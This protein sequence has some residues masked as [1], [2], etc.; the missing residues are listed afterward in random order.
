MSIRTSFYSIF[1]KKGK[2]CNGWM[3]QI[4]T[5]TFVRHETS[6]CSK[7]NVLLRIEFAIICGVIRDRFLDMKDPSTGYRI[8]QEG[9][10]FSKETD[11]I[12]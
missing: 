2:I 11:R 3:N 10:V 1:K 5:L 9:P 6:D 12:T 8:E 7:F 4:S